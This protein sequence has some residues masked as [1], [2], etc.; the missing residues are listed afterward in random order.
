MLRTLVRDAVSFT[1]ALEPG[2]PVTTRRVLRAALLHDG[3]AVL[4]LSRLR[5]AVRWVPG[6]G[7]ATRLLQTALYG[8]EIGKDVTL[9]EGVCLVHTLGVV[10]GGDAS[11]GAR[12]R[13]L[14]GV[15][16]GTARDN[17]YPRIGDDVTIG[18][19]ARV[20]GPVVIGSGAVIG[21]NAV[22]L[23]DVPAGATAVGVPAR[24]RSTVRA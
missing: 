6:A 3:F 13:I 14:G 1:R 9:G 19:G 23:A 11:L 7:R 12:V 5:R 4:A 18:A 8:A 17:G 22:V 16:I 15:T 20:L 10:I 21:A 24:V 2:A